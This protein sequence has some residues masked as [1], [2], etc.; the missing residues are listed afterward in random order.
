MYLAILMCNSS[1]V[2]L[3]TTPS[4]RCMPAI[5]ALLCTVTGWRHCSY[6]TLVLVLKKLMIT[7]RG[8]NPIARSACWSASVSR[9]C[10]RS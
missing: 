4:W 2:S 1:L 6:V 8:Q 10:A 7:H 3:I 9:R 5:H